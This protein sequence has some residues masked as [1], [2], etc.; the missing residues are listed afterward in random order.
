MPLLDPEFLRQRETALQTWFSA[1]LTDLNMGGQCGLLEAVSGDASFR[2]YFRAHTADGPCILVDAPPPHE[3]CG[4]FVKVAALMRQTGVAVPQVL[5]ADLQQGFMCLEDLGS[6]QLWTVLKAWQSQEQPLSADALYGSAFEQLLR[7]QRLPES[8]PLPLYDAPLLQREMDLFAQWFC[9]GLL[10]R[11]LKVHARRMMGDL[12]DSLIARALAQ[13]QGVVHRDYHSRNLMFRDSQAPGV[14]DFQD[15]VIGAQTYDLVS[16]LRDCYISWPE[17]QVLEWVE[18]FRQQAES[19]GIRV[20]GS[21]AEYRQDFDYMGMQRHLKVLGI[22]SR[23]WLRDGK[24]GY[25]SD[26][27]L[28]W[29]YLTSVMGLYPEFSAM[30]DWLQSVAGPLLSSSLMRARKDAGV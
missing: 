6:I 26:I 27:P 1:Q 24:A 28:T 20:S 21:A 19:A 3:N 16:L 25:L 14:I 15:A 10:Q 4:P 8:A 2:R 17:Q 5:A 9:E 22:F 7:I 11:S 29:H 23:L 12:F 30:H 13:P 18:Q